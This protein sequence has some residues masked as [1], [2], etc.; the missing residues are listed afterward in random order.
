MFHFV[1]G[2][3]LRYDFTQ[4][5]L[6]EQNAIQEQFFKRSTTGLSLGFSFS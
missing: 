4:S 1:G 6:Y 3:E 5:L 2:G